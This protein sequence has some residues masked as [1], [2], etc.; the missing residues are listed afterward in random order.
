MTPSATA[1]RLVEP[2]HSHIPERV[3]TF[4]PLV[5]EHCADAGFVPDP[6][7]ADALDVLFA[8][9]RDGKS[10]AF[11]FC[12]VCSRQNL[13]T[14]LFKMACLGW[15]FVTDERLVVWS[16][17]E[18]STTREAFRD[19]VVLIEGYEEFSKLLAPG[20]SNGIMRGNGNEAIELRTG[21]RIIFKA[22]TNGGGRGLT[23]NKVIL[24]EGMY[25]KASHMGSLLPTMSA[26]DDPQIVV[27][28]SA[29]LVDS[30]V[31]RSRSGRA[32]V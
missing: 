2:A 22:R 15:L 1:L 8:I 19:L 28:A 16:A 27:G 10:V 24:D 12:V 23:G 6:E 25:V 17:H 21:Q 13:K 18:M 26:V 31:L 14:G 29:G 3:E 11:E 7:Q 9:G 20:P 32:H 5:A 4:G 30:A